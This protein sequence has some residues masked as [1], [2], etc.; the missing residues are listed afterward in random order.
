[1]RIHF[2]HITAIPQRITN[3]DFMLADVRANVSCPFPYGYNMVAIAPAIM[4]AFKA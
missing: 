1:M 3:F 4:S 2:Y